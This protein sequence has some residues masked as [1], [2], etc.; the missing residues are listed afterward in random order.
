MTVR[1]LFQLQEI[2]DLHWGSPSKRLVFRACYDTRIPEHQRFYDATPTGELTMLV[3]NP[4]ALEQ[5]ELGRHY[6][7]DADKAPAFE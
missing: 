2:H 4:A 7:F 1:C 6:Y 3:N 5:F